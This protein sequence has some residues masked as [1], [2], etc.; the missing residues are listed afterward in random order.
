MQ[1][2]V[3]FHKRNR[4]TLQ[5]HMQLLELLEVPQL[6]D[7]CIRTGLLDEALELALFVNNLERRHLL[8]HEVKTGSESS[9][10]RGADVIQRIVG[11]VHSL[12]GQLQQSL[13]LQ[14]TEV[15]A[16][17]RLIL[18]MATL[19]KMDSLF[20]DRLLSLQRFQGS[21]GQAQSL[22]N[23]RQNYV[24]ACEAKHQMDF[25]EARSVYLLRQQGNVPAV[26]SSS[27][28]S[29]SGAAA[30][31]GGSGGL[32]AYGKA[33][34]LLELRRGALF[35]VVAHFQ[36]LF[37]DAHATATSSDTASAG[38]AEYQ[39]ASV[40]HA[41]C[42]A[43]VHALCQE[44]RE[45]LPLVDGAGLRS[46]CEQ[47]L[48]LAQ[49][50]SQVGCDLTHS[51][52]ALFDEAVM[53]RIDR[54]TQALAAHFSTILA[55]ER[56]KL[57]GT[58]RE[59]IIPL[60][61]AQDTTGEVSNL[62]G[63]GPAEE[64]EIDPPMAVLRYPPLTFALNALLQVVSLLRDFPLRSLQTYAQDALLACLHQLGE[65]IVSHRNPLRS[66]AEKYLGEASTAPGV[67]Q[68]SAPQASSASSGGGSVGGSG[69]SPVDMLYAQCLA[70]DVAPHLLA[71]LRAIFDPKAVDLYLRWR[72][73]HPSHSSGVGVSGR[74]VVQ[75][76]DEAKVLI[77]EEATAELLVFWRRLV[78]AGLLDASTLASKQAVALQRAQASVATSAPVPAQASIAA[79]QET[80]TGPAPETAEAGEA[81]F[82]EAAIN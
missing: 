82:G 20:I 76:V 43:Q 53:Q 28:A 34:E 46:L 41:W 58:D 14:L 12:L 47:A 54:A 15:S 33:M 5:H 31:G 55:T 27:S 39:G 1:A 52:L 51:I 26:P 61:N 59:Q 35:Q 63:K 64:T 3:S 65:N 60:L 67:R 62:L 11:E 81:S 80:A 71:C 25:L 24:Q 16:L 38:G 50:M 17:P 66:L 13:L 2:F 19:R 36:A 23:V 29:N 21:A 7:A 48:Y 77:G 42:V 22:E 57:A 44:L 79:L 30:V 72:T 70:L 8:A 75:D 68:T 9:P 45:L 32:G 10:R 18:I 4:K 49:R 40:L 37:L 74:H 78:D 6:V 73:S 56:V 69:Q